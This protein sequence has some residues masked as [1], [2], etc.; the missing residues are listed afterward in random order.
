MRVAP[1]SAAG[2][3][4]TV[5]VSA[6]AAP[7][8]V[9]VTGR[10][11]AAVQH[12]LS[13][14]P[15]GSWHST[16]WTLF[17]PL[18]LL[19]AVWLV[20][21][22]ASALGGYLTV[23]VDSRLAGAMHSA[24]MRALLGTARVDV[25]DSEETQARVSILNEADR[26]AA[27]S[28]LA[29]GVRQS[30]SGR[31]AGVGTALLLVPLGW[32][33]VLIL[34]GAWWW[35]GRARARALGQGSSFLRQ[36]LSTPGMRRAAYLRSLAV[37]HRAAKEVRIFG[38]ADWVVDTYLAAWQEGMT[39]VWAARRTQNREVLLAAATVAAAQGTAFGWLTVQAWSGA[40]DIA[41]VAVLGQACIAM[42]AWSG[43]LDNQFQVRRAL[44]AVRET[45][46]LVD[47]LPLPPDPDSRRQ[48]AARPAPAASHVVFRD[49]HFTYPGAELPVLAGVDL[50]IEPGQAIAIVG[51]NG[52]GKS[53]II[54]LL[55]GLYQPCVGHIAVDAAD[56]QTARSRGMLSVIFQDFAHLPLSLRDNVVPG[57]AGSDDAL[58]RTAM[59][60]ANADALA[61]QLPMGL[62]TIL[63]PAYEKGT[64]LSGGQWQKVALARALAAA[65]AGASVLVL[66]EPAS[67]LDIQAEQELFDRL[68]ALP[69]PITRIFITHRLASIRRADRI[70]VLHDGRIAEAGTHDEL[71]ECGG[72]YAEMF[73]LQAERFH[74]AAAGPAQ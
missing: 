61:E 24:T 40:L 50:S 63:S 60:L 65:D 70:A 48:E 36:S 49:V 62:D 13:Q 2:L 11:V 51:L 69:R 46:E 6:V 67:H 37:E 1:W 64:D 28:T 41:E 20:G 10:V 30:I 39:T 72:R 7:A 74:P 44:D 55:C 12:S 73:Q 57:I 9:L 71:M 66:D 32:W 25:I 68:F 59:H 18:L 29:Q 38:L 43:N 33:W 31:L 22:G 14:T 5:L 56:P 54:K 42:A 16:G 45:W 17:A 21:A 26:N 53:T 35:L 23:L 27:L 19:C 4:A 52:A 8:A 3:V 34:P 47:S 58:V 15:S